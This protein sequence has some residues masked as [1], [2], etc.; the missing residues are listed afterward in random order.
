MKNNILSIAAICATMMACNSQNEITNRVELP[1]TV[2]NEAFAANVESI[3]VMNLEMGDDWAFVR[4]PWMA[5]GD[6]YIYIL[7]GS[8]SRLSCFDRHTGDKLAARTINGNGPGEF[9]YMSAIFCNGDTLCIYDSKGNILQYDPKISFLGKLYE[10]GADYSYFR[11]YRLASSNYA[12]VTSNGGNPSIILTDNHF[13]ILSQHFPLLEN[14]FTIA[15]GYTSCYSV[16]DTVRCFLAGENRIFELC[17]ETEKYIELI[18]PNP[19]PQEVVEQIRS[20]TVDSRKAFEY[21]GMFGNLVE[22][23][24]FISFVYNFNGKRHTSLLDKHTNSVVS[25]SADGGTADIAAEIIVGFF[26]NTMI[27][28]SDGEYIYSKVNNSRLAELLEGHDNLLD[29]RL[30]KTQAEYRAYIERNADY[31]KGLEPEERDVANI[32]LKIK[33]KD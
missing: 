6:N 17:G 19:L 22:S 25:I 30:K 24:R 14:R 16:G 33:L 21:D 13:N 26:T 10:F 29:A 8:Q 3:S 18:V 7:D 1:G 12:W 31:L 11:P 15:L 28:Q 27:F 32:L 20:H 5:I 4:F 2:D 9:Q 23:G